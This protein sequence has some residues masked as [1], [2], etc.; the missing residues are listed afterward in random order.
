MA[1]GYDLSKQELSAHLNDEVVAGRNNHAPERKGSWHL[2]R[3]QEM[4]LAG[5][6]SSFCHD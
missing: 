6:D 2:P 3:T 1:A 5:D 4:K